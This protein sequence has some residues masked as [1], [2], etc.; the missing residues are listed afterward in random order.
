MSQPRAYRTEAIVLRGVNLGEAD[1]LLVLLTPDQG[2][3]KAIVRGARRPTSKLGGHV[4]PLTYCLLMLA[5]GR[6]WDILTGAEVLDSYLPLRGNLERCGWACY[7]AE[8]VDFFAPEGQENRPLFELLRATLTTLGEAQDG[9]AVLRYFE[10]QLLGKLGYG[11][12]LRVCPLCR[13]PLSSP[14]AFSPALGGAV[15]PPCARGEK[16]TYRLSPQ[17]LQSLRSLQETGEFSTSP[18][19]P[20]VVQEMRWV[21][22]GYIRYILEREVKAA[23][24]LD[25]LGAQGDSQ[26]ILSC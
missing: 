8:L 1:R 6:S 14:G 13:S 15:C 26:K 24:F 11:P 21:L 23:S 9:E 2:K 17:A 19:S 12:E 22:E 7:C 3:L 4:E 16:G 18:M 25:S 10:L 5:R 20:A